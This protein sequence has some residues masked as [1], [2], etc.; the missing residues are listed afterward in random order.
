MRSTGCGGVRAHG[1]DGLSLARGNLNV[2]G[3]AVRRH[4]QWKRTYQPGI[5]FGGVGN[6]YS[7][8]RVS[9]GAHLRGL[10]KLVLLSLEDNYGDTFDGFADAYNLVELYLSRL[11]SLQQHRFSSSVPKSYYFQVL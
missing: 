9:D 5:H 1:G 6:T 3:N 10:T 8:N 4:G 7:R 11:S 2:S